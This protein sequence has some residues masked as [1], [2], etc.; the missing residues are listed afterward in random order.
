MA[1]FSRPTDAVLAA[2][3]ML[4]EIE[5]DNSEHGASSIILK[6]GAH[7]GPSIAVTLNET[8]DLPVSQ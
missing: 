5:R 1:V 3:H 4:D 2:L 6:I 7:C 8:R